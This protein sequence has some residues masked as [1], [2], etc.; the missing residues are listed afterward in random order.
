MRYINN[1]TTSYVGIVMGA[2]LLFCGYKIFTNPEAI[3][4]QGYDKN[5]SNIL[6]YIFCL[7]G[8]FR[9]YRAYKIL[10]KP[11]EEE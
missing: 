5:W 4:G 11:P 10:S 7:Y 1:K 8:A 6:G 9:I 2:V 3:M